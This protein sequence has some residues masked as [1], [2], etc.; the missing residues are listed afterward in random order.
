MANDVLRAAADAADAA[1][2]AAATAAAAAAVEERRGG[3]RR[4][5]GSPVNDADVVLLARSLQSEGRLAEAATILGG[6]AVWITAP[7]K[8]ELHVRIGDTLLELAADELPGRPVPLAEPQIAQMRSSAVRASSS[9]FS[10]MMA[11]PSSEP[12]TASCLAP[13]IQAWRL[14]SS[15]GCRG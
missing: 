8:G 2:I 7:S 6:R 13:S 1:A 10:S 9:A 12:R 11:M 14:S 4:S 15:T 3:V 5:P